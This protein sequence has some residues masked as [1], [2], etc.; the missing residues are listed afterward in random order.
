MCPSV[1]SWSGCAESAGRSGSR[2][3]SDPVNS[4]KLVWDRGGGLRSGGVRFRVVVGG[5]LVSCCGSVLNRGGAVWDRGG[6]GFGIESGW[7]EIVVEGGLR[8]WW[9]ASQ[10][11]P[12]IIK[13][14]ASQS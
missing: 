10:M 1:G 2:L 3:S 6:A 13:L 5:G 8:S 12:G 14:G 7:V 11:V 4:W 9:I